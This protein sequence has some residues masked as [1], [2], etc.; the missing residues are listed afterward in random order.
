MAVPAFVFGVDPG[1][2]F[3]GF[4]WIVLRLVV[5]LIGLPTGMQVTARRRAEYE[6]HM[7][8]AG[9]GP[10]AAKGRSASEDP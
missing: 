6:S 7:M 8:V 10:F 2:R 5:G 9:P 1:R 3:P 4:L